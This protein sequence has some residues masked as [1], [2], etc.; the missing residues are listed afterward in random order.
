MKAQVAQ[1]HH[2]YVKWVEQ[3]FVVLPSAS[4]V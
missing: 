4:E 1:G 3:M 2:L